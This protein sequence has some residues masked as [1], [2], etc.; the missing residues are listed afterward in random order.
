MVAKVTVVLGEDAC[1]LV[2]GQLLIGGAEPGIGHGIAPTNA[3]AQRYTKINI[4]H[5]GLHAHD[6][7]RA[8]HS[9]RPFGNVAKWIVKHI[10]SAEAN[11]IV[12][13]ISPIGIV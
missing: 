13:G 11:P 3:I 8:M 12:V 7:T 2:A 6:Q 1:D 5:D 9:R 4:S 10:T